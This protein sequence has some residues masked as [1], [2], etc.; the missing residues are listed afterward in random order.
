MQKI[1]PWLWFDNQAEEAANFYVSVFK[2]SRITD[3]S[4][5]GDE[6]PGPAGSVMVVAFELDGL[7]FMA[8][9]GG[10]SENYSS[11]FYV[12]CET[13]EEIDRLWDALGEGGET[14][15]CGWLKDRFGVSWNIVPSVFA[16][17]MSDG[18]PEKRSRVMSAML[19]MT[20]LEIAGLRRAYEGA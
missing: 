9:N 10:P 2:N 20:K 3:V 4:R 8:L 19:G 11:A 12:D 15:V 13:Q 16:E 5:Y 6:G 1:R 14:N 18:N 17:L 7:E